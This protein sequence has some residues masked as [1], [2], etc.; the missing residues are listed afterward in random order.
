MMTMK[1]ALS[2]TLN[3]T[4]NPLVLSLAFLTACNSGLDRSQLPLGLIP[5]GMDISELE[6]QGLQATQPLI[7]ITNR[8]GAPIQNATLMIGYRQGDP[9]ENNVLHTNEKGA[10]LTPTEWTNRQPVTIEAPGYIRTTFY[11]QQPDNLVFQLNEADENRHLELAGTTTGYGEL[12]K[13]GFLDVGLVVPSLSREQLVMW[14]VA[15]FIS[16]EKDTLSAI[17]K[18]ISIPS[19][20]A[21]PRQTENYILPITL[22]KPEYRM[23]FGRPGKHEVM[24]MHIKFPFKK[25]ID[26]AQKG[27]NILALAND[28]EFLGF[29]FR[30]VNFTDRRLNLDFPVHEISFNSQIVFPTPK[31]DSNFEML[32]MATL[33]GSN[34]IRPTDM[35]NPTSGQRVTLKSLASKE[36]V[37]A[38]LAVLRKTSSDPKNVNLHEMSTAYVKDF[39]RAPEFYELIPVPSMDREVLRASPPK[40]LGSVL[41][42]GM[43]AVLSEVNSRGMDGKFPVE[44]RLRQWEFYGAQWSSEMRIPE[45]KGAFPQAQQNPLRWEVFYLGSQDKGAVRPGPEMLEKCTHVTRNVLNL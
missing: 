24:A 41:S 20:I 22:N 44:N 33:E 21:V 34:S 5:Q 31:F 23:F 17:G 7:Q 4:L 26:E 25:V 16:P 6:T 43:Y 27:Q 9:F 28:F 18:S 45:W 30:E 19:N 40:A 13:D 12:K 15:T 37:P 11:D 39:S 1:S 2:R 8:L 35:K 14:D 32:T 3:K 38:V 42:A 36:G 29:S 10:V